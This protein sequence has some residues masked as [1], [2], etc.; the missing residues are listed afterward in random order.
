MPN[1]DAAPQ[2]IYTVTCQ[3]NSVNEYILSQQV[4]EQSNF[5]SK[6]LCLVQNFSFTVN[7]KRFVKSGPTLFD[8]GCSVLSGLIVSTNFAK[9]SQFP[10]H[11]KPLGKISY[12]VRA[13]DKS[14]MPITGYIHSLYLNLDKKLFEFKDVPVFDTLSF[15]VIIGLAARTKFAL[16]FGDK[17]DGTYYLFYNEELRKRQIKNRTKQNSVPQQTVAA[18]APEVVLSPRGGEGAKPPWTEGC[19]APILAPPLNQTK[20]IKNKINQGADKI[21]IELEPECKKVGS[22]LFGSAPVVC[23]FLPYYMRDYTVNPNFESLNKNS[24]ES[25]IIL[26]L[27]NQTELAPLHVVKPKVS[28]PEQGANI[29]RL[30]V[31]NNDSKQDPEMLNSI[32]QVENPP[33]SFEEVTI[34]DYFECET[35]TAMSDVDSNSNVDLNSAPCPPTNL[36]HPPLAKNDNVKLAH[37][38]TQFI[39]NVNS[40][41][42]EPKG[43]DKASPTPVGDDGKLEVQIEQENQKCDCSSIHCKCTCRKCAGPPTYEYAHRELPRGI[44][45]KVKLSRPGFVMYLSGV[46]E[47]GEAKFCIPPMDLSRSTSHY[48]TLP[49]TPEGGDSSKNSLTTYPHFHIPEYTIAEKVIVPNQVISRTN[50]EKVRLVIANLNDHPVK[51]DNFHAQGRFVK[52]TFSPRVVLP[53]S[54]KKRLKVMKNKSEIERKTVAKD[55]LRKL[56]QV[57]RILYNTQYEKDDHVDIVECTPNNLNPEYSKVLNDPK[58]KSQSK[59]AIFKALSLDD[60]CYLK[61]RPE[62][63]S[64]VKALIEEYLDVFPRQGGS[65]VGNTDLMELDLKLK[66]GATPPQARCRNL[67]PAML[68]DLRKQLG[69][70]LQEDI[71]EP[72]TSSFSSA[73]VPVKKK[74]GQIRWAVDYR[75]VNKVLEGDSYP[76]PNITNLLDRAAGKRIY[77]S[78]DSSQAFLSLKLKP[79]ARHITSFICPDGQFQF[80]RMPF[81]LKVAPSTY[82]RFIA[83][84]LSSIA[85]GDISVYLDDVLLASDS[86][87]EHLERLR[88]L[89]QAHREAGLL[90]NPS[91]TNLFRESIEFLGHRLD[92]QG[93]HAADTLIDVITKWPLPRT[94]KEMASFLGLCTYYSSFIP[95]YSHIAAKLQDLKKE[96]V[97]TWTPELK[98]CF[99]QLIDSFK[100]DMV[101]TTPR[102]DDLENNPLILT[103]DFSGLAMGYVLS[104][105]QDGHDRLIAAAG[106]KCNAAERAYGST[107]G[108]MAALVY[109]VHRFQYYLNLNKFIIRTDNKSL[110]YLANMN[111]V[112]NIWSR[113]VQLLQPYNF[114][115]QH[116]PGK[117]NKVADAISR[118][119]RLFGDEEEP[120]TRDQEVFNAMEE[121]FDNLDAHVAVLVPGGSLKELMSGD[122]EITQ[123]LAGIKLQ[124]D[125]DPVL[126]IVG[127]WVDRGS[128]PTKEE[129]VGFNLTTYGRLYPELCRDAEGRLVRRF[130]NCFFE[131]VEQV[132]LPHAFFENAFKLAHMVK[133][134]PHQGLATTLLQIQ[135]FFYAP[136]LHQTVEDRIRLCDECRLRNTNISTHQGLFNRTVAGFPNQIWSIDLIGKITPDNEYVYILSV[137]DVYSRFLMLEPLRNKKATTVAE[138]LFRCVKVAGLPASLKSDFGAEFENL[139]LK[140]IGEQWEIS[141]QKS[142]PYFHH[143]NMVERQHREINRQLKV[144]IPDP[145][146]DW[147]HALISIC[148]ARNSQVNRITGYTPNRLFFGRESFHPL[149]IHL[150]TLPDKQH[151]AEQLLELKKNTDII[152]QRLYL[153]NQQYFKQQAAVYKPHPDKFAVGDRVYFI[154]KYQPKGVSTRLLHRWAGPGTVQKISEDGAYLHISTIN[155]AKKEQ[156]ICMHISAVRRAVDQDRPL[157]PSDIPVEPEEFTD[158]WLPPFP[159]VPSRD[160]DSER[161]SEPIQAKVEEEEQPN[162]PNFP[163]NPPNPPPNPPPAPAAPPTA[164]HVTRAGRVCRAPAYLADYTALMANIMF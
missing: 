131:Q 112:N 1:R 37:Q 101:R 116:V 122:S 66:P 40:N 111:H 106:K 74:N 64:K 23:A 84:A 164:G 46:A 132:L 35:A 17:S 33:S 82:S 83:A 60:N 25:E 144:L 30:N 80:K 118:N 117:N 89:L 87:E 102:W 13:A 107:K 48:I 34:E 143:S 50:K 148:L 86:D 163:P 61:A 150:K 14:V 160:E 71:I 51:I 39:F 96:I 68:N 154:N 11:E 72:C 114:T 36:E 125:Q 137:L 79:S 63:L 69:E 4:I 76:L 32:E 113:W 57:K 59:D 130:K 92:S 157:A 42:F 105:N 124:Q 162:L 141:F 28:S 67:N 147:T 15:D 140:A 88:Q 156:L 139:I 108:E 49:V 22:S 47:G 142:V 20:D 135:R 18:L 91:K 123:Q 97:I 145:P 133:T 41:S 3:I 62:L 103:T 24:H 128:P 6:N 16:D 115:I 55:A 73:L 10:I 90:I 58:L 7:R 104:Q 155:K 127:S 56:N 138:A 31:N 29:E 151:P 21:K 38:G 85:G 120:L 109:G 8:T 12:R 110:T 65:T 2:M 19:Q 78:L 53:N 119:P 95:N 93:I 5:D 27:K 44:K 152:T 77:S 99:D 94:G 146:A 100:S 149:Q 26:G 129:L 9:E 43:K 159:V 121:V 126:K 45:H 52:A 136:D 70:W 75:D 153:A 81:G 54:E 158:Y 134:S 161:E 98:A